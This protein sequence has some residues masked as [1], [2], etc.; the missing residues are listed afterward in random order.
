MVDLIYQMMPYSYRVVPQEAR[1]VPEYP[2][3]NLV[4]RR[5]VATDFDNYLTGEDTLFCRRIRDGIFYHPS[6]LVYHRRR[7]TFKKFCNQISTYGKH[8]GF[9]IREALFG[10]VASAFVYSFNFIKG[11]FTRR[12][13]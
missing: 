11:L 8:R 1:I 2:T 5:D 9:L 3:F 12:P 13:S 6:I 10:V 4:V 7:P